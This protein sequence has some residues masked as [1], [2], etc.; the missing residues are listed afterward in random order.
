ML[1][2]EYA[3]FTRAQIMPEIIP[4]LHPAVVHLPIALTLV[5]LLFSL[6]A[7]LVPRSRFATQWAIIGHWTLWLSA[8]T[9]IVAATLGWQAYNSVNHDDAGHLAMTLHRNWALPTTLGLILLAA[10]DV[11]RHRDIKV[12]PWLTVV[13]LL[14]ISLSVLRIAWLGGEVVD[15]YGF[16]VM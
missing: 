12:M 10:W 15:R 11:W 9:A 1:P 2:P 3:Q 5:A 13:I 16:G 6:A 8:L 4:N 7:R 14:V